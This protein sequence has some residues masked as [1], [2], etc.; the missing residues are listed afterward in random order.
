MKNHKVRFNLSR[1]ENY[2]KWKVM[3]NDGRVE[4]YHPADV[5]LVL[6]NCVLTNN[7]TAAQK[8]FTGVTTKVVCAYIRCE[9]VDIITSDF[10]PEGN[11]LLKYNPREMPFWN[12]DGVNQ[13]GNFYEELFS[14][15]YKIYSN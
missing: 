10:R 4:Y 7:R 9:S 15:D 13:D 1:G 14:I 5:Q 12:V 8:I 2:M 11:T 3:Y 6:R